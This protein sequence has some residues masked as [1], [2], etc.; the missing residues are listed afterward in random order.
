MDADLPLQVQAA[1][2]ER[3]VPMRILPTVL[4]PE[5]NAVPLRGLDVC[6]TTSVFTADMPESNRLVLFQNLV[7]FPNLAATIIT[8]QDPKAAVHAFSRIFRIHLVGDIRCR[9]AYSLQRNQNKQ[10]LSYLQWWHP[11][12]I[13][14]QTRNLS[15]REEY[16]PWSS[17]HITFP[18]KF[19]FQLFIKIFN[20]QKFTEWLM[21][22]LYLPQRFNNSWLIFLHIYFKI[23][24]KHHD[25]SNLKTL[26]CL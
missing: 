6:S 21:N 3:W 14:S 19:C 12:R 5:I 4:W 23:C 16:L 13:N 8:F 25:S 18:I 10:C 11:Y 17:I 26:V 9:G 22:I 24:Y 7:S 2:S 15:I 20:I 1:K